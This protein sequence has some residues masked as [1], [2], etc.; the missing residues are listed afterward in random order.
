MI[1]EKGSGQ[2]SIENSVRAS[3]PVGASDDSG[4]NCN[5]LDLLK[6]LPYYKKPV[7]FKYWFDAERIPGPSC[8]APVLPA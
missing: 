7:M 8:V 3:T 4:V 6:T 5:F 2:L 1:G